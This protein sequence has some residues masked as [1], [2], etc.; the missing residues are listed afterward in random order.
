MRATTMKEHKQTKDVP[1]EMML[2]DYLALD[3]TRL[4][5]DRTLLSFIRTSLYLLV[6]AFAIVELK[7]LEDFMFLTWILVIASAVSLI[8]GITNYMRMKRK[9]RDYYTGA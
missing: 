7:S 9:L 4:A 3:R 6:T 2:R 5:N 1:E 8:A